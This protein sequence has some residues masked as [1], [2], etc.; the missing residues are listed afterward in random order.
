[1]QNF[2]KNF[3]FAIGVSVVALAVA[4]VDG[5]LRNGNSISAAGSALIIALLLGILEL[6]LSFDNA[7]VNAA[8]LKNMDPKWQ[9]RFLTWGIL[10]AVF[11]MRFVFPIV[12]VASPP[13]WASSRSCR[14]RSATRKST[15][16]TWR[17]P[18]CRSMR[19]AARS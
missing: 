9:R 1:M 14:K 12:I 13:G 2:V 18:A 5:Y 6:S 17:K 15:A 10:I 19:S 11:G 4:V 8:V 7:V 16:S 3:G